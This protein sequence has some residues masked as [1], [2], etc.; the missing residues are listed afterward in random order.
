VTGRGTKAGKPARVAWATVGGVRIKHPNKVWWPA[1]GITKL[2]V[3]NHYAAVASRMLP[4]LKD[5]PLTAE[6]CPDGIGGECFY[7]KNFE[8]GLGPNV[9]TRAI[10]AQNG[11]EIVHYVIGG[12]VRTLLTLVE[13]GCIAVHVMNCRVGSLDRPDWLTFDLDPSSGEFAEAAKASLTLRKILQELGLHSYPKTTG[14]RGLHVLVPL[15]HGPNQERVRDFAHGVCQEMARRSPDLIT[16]ELAKAKRGRRVFADWIRNAFGE[17]IAAP[18][19]VRR[20]AGAPVSVPL[21][22]DEVE[23]K[24][25][26]NRFELRNIETRLAQPD[27]WAASLLRTQRLPDLPLRQGLPKL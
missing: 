2:D 26:P 13:L 1:E 6:R 24:L 11:Q 5:R 8:H 7:Q 12:S 16:T 10:P 19:S 27:P 4:W 15:R 17:T 9:P 25:D 22:W 21:E 23:P 14:G 3:A 20:R 18:Y